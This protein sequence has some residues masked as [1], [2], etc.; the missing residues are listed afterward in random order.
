MT[1]KWQ[2]WS[3]SPDGME[4]RVVDLGDQGYCE[5]EALYRNDRQVYLGWGGADFLALPLGEAPR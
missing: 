5:R 3:K 1:K 4:W 2:V